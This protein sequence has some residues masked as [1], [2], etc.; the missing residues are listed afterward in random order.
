MEERA[1]EEGYLEQSVRRILKYCD[2]EKKMIS[3]DMIVKLKLGTPG[4]RWGVIDKETRIVTD[5]SRYS[6]CIVCDNRYKEKLIEF[7]LGYGKTGVWKSICPTCIRRYVGLLAQAQV[8]EVLS[9]GEEFR[10]RAATIDLE[11]E[12]KKTKKSEDHSVREV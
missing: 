9:K 5:M 4:Y 1:E 2:E 10:K 11:K 8:N 6:K 3:S 12:C 7:N